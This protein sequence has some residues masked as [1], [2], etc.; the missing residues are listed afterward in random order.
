MKYIIIV[1]IVLIG[2]GIFM[3]SATREKAPAVPQKEYK[4]VAFGDSL[5]AGFKVDPKDNYPTIL[6]QRLKTIN[7]N[8]TIVNMGVS[9][10]TSAQGL[11]RIDS[12]I[13]EKPDVVLLCLGA[14]DLLRSLSPFEAK[15][16]IES[17][18]VQLQAK[19]IVVV[20]LGV[21]TSIN[22][23]PEYR[24]EF[25]AIYPDL[26]EKYNLTLIPSFLSGVVLNG[27]L[28]IPDHLHPNAAGYLKIVD[29]NIFPEIKNMFK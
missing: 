20:L 13:A 4:V 23:T 5:T 22:N 16:N 14:N 12:V 15:K 26:A 27:K 6:E 17:I 29:E 10:D 9:G 25:D 18:I 1:L 7:P 19:G 24:K 8:I 11:A 3:Y 2:G 28:T 21:K